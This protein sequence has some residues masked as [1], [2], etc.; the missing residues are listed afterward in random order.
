MSWHEPDW[1]PPANVHGLVTTRVGGM[2]AG[3][4]G[5]FNLALHVGDQPAHVTRNRQ[6]LQHQASLPA[7]P[8]WLTQVHGTG[9]YV[10]GS[11]LETVPGLQ[12][13]IEADAAFCQTSGQVL[14]I[15]VADCLPILICSRDG[16][17]IAAAHAGWRGLALGVIGQVVARFASDDLLAW[18]GPAIGPCHYEVD[19]QVRS[20][21][22]G[23]TGFAVG[24]DAQHWMLDLYAIARQ[25]LQLAGVNTV[26]GG[27]ECTFCD[28]AYYSYRRDGVTGRMAALIWRD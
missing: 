6:L 14:A 5:A 11:Q 22:Q 2:S 3:V 7:T 9:V 19:A 21:F 20:R 12:R 18:M 16:K 17:E 8:A 13:P 27:G 23:S 4:Y 1:T 28:P 10:P 15:M 26:S 25:Q 24:R